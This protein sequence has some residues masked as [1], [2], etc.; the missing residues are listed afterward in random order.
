MMNKNI[1]FEVTG[2]GPKALIFIHGWLGNLRWWDDQVK[3]FSDQFQVVVMDLPGHGKSKKS[4]VGYSST[5]YA[6]AIKE[7]A[8]QL[9]A[10]EIILIGHS[11]AGAYILE[12]AAGI[13]KTKS[14]ILVDTL[15]NLDQHPSIEVAEQMTFTQ[16]RADFR[17]AVENV[18]P[19]Y[20]FSPSTPISVQRRLISEFLEAEVEEAISLLAPLYRMDV[21]SFAQNTTLPVTAINSTTPPTNKD[22][23]EKYFSNYHLME[24][25]ATGHY[26]MLEN[27]LE[28]NALLRSV[29]S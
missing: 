26:P 4:D 7:V 1:N 9:N 3:D 28:F 10:Q 23:N 16:L 8:S 24:A 2:R 11:M 27:P 14:L 19:K 22:V 18:L 17:N 12:A 29:L 5:V 20:L 21:K 15:K 13:P 6:E 25:N